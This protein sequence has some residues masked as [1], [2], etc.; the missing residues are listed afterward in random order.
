M[1]SRK[2]RDIV[3]KVGEYQ[4]RNT[5]ETKGR[6][7][8]VGALM[9]NDDGDGSYFIMLKRTFNPA[10]VP[11]QDARES[12]LLSCYVPRDRDQQQDQPAR[13]PAKQQSYADASGGRPADLDDSEIPF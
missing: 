10:G 1:A 3:A 6:F 8:N 7:E 13:Q 2:I 5:G 4:D 12:V 11:G 9:Q